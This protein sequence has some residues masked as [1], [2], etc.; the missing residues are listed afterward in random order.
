LS[1]KA[2]FDIIFYN[3]SGHPLKISGTLLR[4]GIKYTIPAEILDPNTRE[5][6]EKV[7][8]EVKKVLATY[9]YEPVDPWR[10][11]YKGESAGDFVKV[12][13]GWVGLGS[14]D[15]SIEKLAKLH[16]LK[17]TP[18]CSPILFVFPRSSNVCV[19]YF[20]VYVRKDDV[21]EFRKWFGDVDTFSFSQG[22]NIWT[23]YPEE[24]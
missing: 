3:G 15:P 19:T 8:D 2:F 23:L 24:A 13:E 6:I 5:E 11:Y 4:R 16:K 10:G 9:S 14:S 1:E 20:D 7:I 18:P 12:V 22:I 21:H 17:E